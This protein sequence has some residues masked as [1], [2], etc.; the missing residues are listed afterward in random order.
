MESIKL[1]LQGE[2]SF[3]VQEAY[4][5]LRTNLLFCGQDI[6]VVA[7]TSCMEN[8]G[9]T[10]ICLNL[11]KSLAELNRNVLVIDADMRKSVM[12]GRDTTAK[13]VVGL[14]EM[15]TGMNSLGECLYKTQ[16]ETLQ[17]M[18]AG[19][20]PPNPVELLNGKYFQQLLNELRKHYDYIIIDPP[21]LGEVIDAAVVAPCCDGTILVL[22]DKNV[23]KKQMQ[24]VVEQLRKSGSKILGVVRNNIRG[25][26]RRYYY[27]KGEY[28]YR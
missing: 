21:P 12:A 7:V 4:K 8:E 10:T 9:K 23:R 5:V 1:Q 27:R 26:D 24:D 22:G 11:A 17:V 28:G 3:P 20:Y 2:D 25:K 16:Y 18:F 15:L 19:K 6:H 14:S 13:N